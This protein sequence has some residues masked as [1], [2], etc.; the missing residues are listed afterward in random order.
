VA[1]RRRRG[2]AACERL[3]RRAQPAVGAAFYQQ[4]ELHRLCGEF[5]QAEAAYRQA[6]RSGRD[7]QPGLARLR[8]A[9]G[10][11]D[12]AEATILRA[13]AGAQDRVARAQ[14]LPAL[15]EI[16][17]AAGDVEAARA[18][19]DDLSILA[20]DLAAPLLRGLAAHAEGA[21]LLLEGATREPRSA[22]CGK[23]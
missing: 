9:Q 4:G 12:A 7:P 17:L 22:R 3:L 1:G 11:V 20:G 10:Q 19:A 23:R 6:S 14:M 18:A 21:V 13:A 15:V 2:A 5:A 8:L 16:M